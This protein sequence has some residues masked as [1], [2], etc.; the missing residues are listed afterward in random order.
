MISVT[1]QS[2]R[3][4]EFTCLRS[5]ELWNSLHKLQMLEHVFL[6]LRQSIPPSLE[7]ASR[8][9]RGSRE[10]Q[11]GV[12]GVIEIYKEFIPSRQTVYEM[13]DTLICKSLCLAMNEMI[14]KYIGMFA[15]FLSE[16]LDH[17]VVAEVKINHA[18][19]AREVELDVVYARIRVG[20]YPAVLHCCYPAVLEG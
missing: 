16:A 4:G 19:A 1:P 6:S 20:R 18:P 17:L 8:Q 2:K 12:D 5:V 7:G 3:V 15:L 11:A 9:I 13:A 14:Y 10:R